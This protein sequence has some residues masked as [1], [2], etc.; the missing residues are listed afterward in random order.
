M[1]VVGNFYFSIFL[2]LTWEFLDLERKRGDSVCQPNNKII[3]LVCTYLHIFFDR[4]ESLQSNFQKLLIF[5]QIKVIWLVWRFR[6]QNALSI[7]WIS[8]FMMFNLI[9]FIF[10][11][12]FICITNLTSV[13]FYPHGH[14]KHSFY[15]TILPYFQCFRIAL[16]QLQ[17]LGQVGH[18]SFIIHNGVCLVMN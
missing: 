10:L 3:D 1:A 14:N 8:D 17:Q 15:V 18:H 4:L 11:E 9:F 6:F 2:R 12:Y 7:N 5:L 16:V 13:P